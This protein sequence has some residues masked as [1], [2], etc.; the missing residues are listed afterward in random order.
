MAG[1]RNPHSSIVTLRA[2]CT[3]HACIGMR[4]DAGHMDP[5]TAQMDEKQD[6]VRHQPAQVQTSAVKKSVATRTSMCVRMNSFHVVVFFAPE[7]GN[8]MALQDV[9]DRLITD[10]SPGWPG[11]RRSGRSPRNGFPEPCGSPRPRD[12]VN[13]GAAWGLSL[14]GAVTLLG[15]QQFPLI[16]F[17]SYMTMASDSALSILTIHFCLLQRLPRSDSTGELVAS[18]LSS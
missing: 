15:H 8:A 10:R 3:I 6:V 13:F 1:A 2:T 4:C 5:P 12:R 17:E 16:T 7:R 11:H 14:G 9:A 18:R